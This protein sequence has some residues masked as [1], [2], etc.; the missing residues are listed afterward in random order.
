MLHAQAQ[1]PYHVV[2]GNRSALHQMISPIR[3]GRHLSFRGDGLAG[4]L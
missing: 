3:S 2:K 1:T 4:C